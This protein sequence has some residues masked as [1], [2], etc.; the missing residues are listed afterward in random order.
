MAQLKTHELYQIETLL[1]EKFKP[2]E[3][4]KKLNKH[5]T[6]IYKEIRRGTVILRDGST[7]L[8]IPVY[9]ADVSQRKRQ[10]SGVKKGRKE[11]IGNDIKTIQ[12]IENK[13]LNE[14][15]SPDAIAMRMKNDDSIKTKLCTGTIYRYIYTGMF[16]NLDETHLAYERKGY[17]KPEMPRR[18]S[19]K[20]LGAKTIEERPKEVNKREEY[21]HWEID[22]VVSGKDE[23]GKM[24]STA[25]ILVLTERAKREQINRKIADRK[26]ETVL[27]EM[28][29]LKRQ[30]GALGFREKFRSFTADNGVEF[31]AYKEI[32]KLG[33]QIYFCH[34]FC[35]SERGSNEAQNK[36]IRRW[37]PKGSN[38]DDYSD[39]FINW[40]AEWINNYP[41]RMFGGL[42]TN[43]YKEIHNTS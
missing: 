40:I 4:A 5:W 17:K 23:S 9:C 37:I 43:E 11:K 34:P 12:Y 1:K 31:S 32:E 22:T 19:Y 33:T 20:M 39:E 24:K 38:I 30:Y 21:G 26:K 42:S 16:E 28:R 29:K 14:K 41:R 25:C 15:F 6:T 35:S 36:L 10:E 8:D 27:K 2:K 3:I 7:W 13:I 18:V